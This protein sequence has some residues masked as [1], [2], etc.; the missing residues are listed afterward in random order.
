MSVL[1]DISDVVAN[2]G[3][4]VGPSVVGI[5][6]GW[7]LGSGVVI[8]EGKVLTNAHNLHSGEVEVTFADGRTATGTVSGVDADGDLAVVSVDTAGAPVVAWASDD[9]AATSG[10]PVV[11]VSNPGGRG[12]QVTFGFVS[13][14]VG[15]FRG[16][17]GRKIQGSVEHTAPL[18]RGSSGSPIVDE[19]GLLLGIN[20]NRLGEGFYAA[21]PADAALRDRVDALGRGESPSKPRLGIGVAP[22]HVARKLRRA[23]GLPE[24]DGLLIRSVE[25]GSPAARAGIEQGDLLVEVAGS[26]VTS[27][28]DLW[29]ALDGVPGAGSF[30]VKVVRGT[31]E[32]AVSVSLTAGDAAQ[33][34]GE[35]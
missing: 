8:A 32:R 34:T 18:A 24:R 12:L 9:G 2:V 16:P 20:T 10:S 22:S 14:V 28:D 26:A 3:A 29:T 15:S 33:A 5:G 13:S 25:E 17:R 4:N 21:V 7:G 35:A 6:G 1:S 31:E 11:A 30:D 19:G 27:V 23:V